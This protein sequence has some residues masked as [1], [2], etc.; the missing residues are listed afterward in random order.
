MIPHAPIVPSPFHKGEQDA[1]ARAGKREKMEAVGKVVIRSFM[2]DQ[3]R[4]FF[5]QLPFIVMGSV[6]EQGWPW[7]SILAG[8]EGFIGSP[9]S[10]KLDLN[11][12]PLAD[13][14]LSG[15]IAAGAPV[16]LLG[17]EVATRRRNRMNATVSA[18]TET[19]LSLDVV[20]SFGNCPKYIQTRDINFVRNSDAV[21]D[22][23]ATDHFTTLD[24]DARAFIAQT[25]TFFVSSYM[26]SDAHLAAE[27]VDVSH[28]GGRNGF[29]KIE[30]NT[31][32][33][34]DY[35]G[36]NFF[37]TIGNFLVN[38]KAGLIFPDFAT[39]DVLMLT[40][41]VEILWEDHPDVVAF[42][43]AERGWRFTLDHGIRIHDA[44]PFRADFGEWSPNSLMADDWAT[45]EARKVG[46]QH[47]NEWRSLR[48]TAIKDE[49][50]SIR[51]FTFDT[52]DDAP[53]LPFE[54]GQFLTVRVTP[55]GA[56]P[57]V[58]TYTISSAPGDVGY[59][60]SVK[61][62]AGGTVSNHMH[63]TLKVGDVV[64]V[65]PPKGAFYIDALEQ[66][67][68]VLFAGGVGVTPMIAM[69]RHVLSESTRKGFTRP[70]TI[71]HAAQTTEQR[72]FLN[73]FRAAE[74][75]S[76]GKIRY[77]SVIGNALDHEQR[78]VD[79]D[80]TGRITPDMIRKTLA[81]D[82]YDFF[83]C[84]PP[85]FMQAVYDG[86]RDLGAADARIFA[87]AFGPAALVRRAEANAVPFV[88]EPEADNATVSFQATGHKQQWEKGDATL[89]EM[90]EAHG[91]APSFSCRNGSCGSCLTKKITGNVVYRTPVI[92]AHAANE[93]LICCAVP[94]AGTEDLVLDL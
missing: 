61:R 67:P 80:A 94:A 62:E 70:L 92:A 48:V 38:P 19:G 16:G 93:V 37:N 76:D 66:R 46:E 1:Q 20:Q 82:D 91:M 69:T 79:F 41:T 44:L 12:R 57:L 22:R 3:H 29:V 13:D 58:R 65:I 39:G 56:A 9:N 30:G 55:K 86:L 83:L 15:A 18:R 24:A 77:V 87:E 23:P 6:D 54:A 60:V 14:P 53:L 32:T 71:F 52:M 47:R 64:E 72:A 85:P 11:A 42:K 10:H 74:A 34:P 8:G 5:E 21:I 84:G 89:L 27:G 33:I 51:S 26:S 28:R 63:D 50:S 36:N 35:T 49:S 2:P 7:A 25:D 73:E 45:S 81:Y 88:P 40:G 43:G 75:N 4:Q 90:A 17:I 59:R 31:L 78:G 68:A